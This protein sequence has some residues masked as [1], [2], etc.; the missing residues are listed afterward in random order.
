M[1]TFLLKFLPKNHN[2]IKSSTWRLLEIKNDSIRLGEVRFFSIFDFFFDFR[3]LYI[4]V[5]TCR[6]DFYQAYCDAVS[7]FHNFHAIQFMKFIITFCSFEVNTI[8]VDGI[9][10]NKF[11]F[12]TF[13]SLGGEFWSTHMFADMLYVQSNFF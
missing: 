6:F 7:H 12:S 11:S 1:L 2:S 13:S 9:D 10:S 8:F 3:P 5:S 4:V